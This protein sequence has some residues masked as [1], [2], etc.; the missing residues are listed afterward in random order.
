MRF[1]RDMLIIGFCMFFCLIAL[2]FDY[3]GRIMLLPVSLILEDEEEPSAIPDAARF[4]PGIPES[5][6]VGLQDQPQPDNGT[7]P[8]P[9]FSEWSRYSPHS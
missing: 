7:I 9:R 8:Y 4:H 1:I 5:V 2:M 6:D 3:L